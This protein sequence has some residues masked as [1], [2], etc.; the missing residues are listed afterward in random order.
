MALVSLGMV[1][2]VMTAPS[3]AAARGAPVT[4]SGLAQPDPLE[5]LG[6]CLAAGGEGDVLLVID[7]SGSLKETDPT[8]QRV[9]AA[10]YLV[11]QLGAY[12]KDS[13]TKLNMAVAGFDTSYAVTSPWRPLNASSIRG[14]SADLDVYKGADNGFE[15]DYWNAVD[16]ARKTL[17][18][19]AAGHVDRCQAWV[20]FSDGRYEIDPRNTQAQQKQYGTTKPYGSQASLTTKAGAD[21]AQ[22]AGLGD[23][24]RDGGLA[25]QLRVQKIVTLAVGLK[26]QGTDAD[27]SAMQGIA[28]GK[29]GG[30][31][32][33][34]HLLSPTPGEFLLASQVDGILFA[35]DRF[36]NPD[37][38]PISQTSKLCAA[39]ACAQGVH[40]FVLDPSISKIHILAGSNVAGSI[41]T[42]TGPG[43]SQAMMFKAGTVAA[44]RAGG[45][46]GLSS[47]WLSDR[48]LAIDLTRATD[49]GWVG[50]WK[51]TFIDPVS[52]SASG[53]AISNIH[54]FGDLEPFW[55]ASSTTAL[56]SGDKAQS[57]TLGLRRTQSKKPVDP[58]A[59]VSSLSVDASLDY[60]SGQSIPIASHIDKQGLG[61]AYR[62][63]L[64]NAKVGDAVIRMT[65]RVV[66]S[67]VGKVA[68]TALEAQSVDFPVKVLAPGSYPRVAG[69]VS[70]GATEGTEPL[71]ATV[72]VVGSGCVWLAGPQESLTRPDGV[73]AP[74][75]SSSY[76]TRD[77][78]LKISGKAS[79][80]MTLQ[81]GSTGNGL[82]S[83]TVNV[84]TAPT[85]ASLP[86]IAVKV[87]YQLEMSR[88]ADV[89]TLIWV[90]VLTLLAGI[91]I[92]V[93]LLYLVKWWNARIPGDSILVG[94]TTGLV[95]STGSFLADSG[96][97]PLREQDLSSVFLAGTDRRS[98]TV[99]GGGKTLHSKMG[100]GITEPGFVILAVPG[101]YSVSSARPSTVRK[102][103]KARLPLAV[104]GH[105]VAVLDAQDPMNGSVEVVLF[106][107]PLSG[108]WADL[109]ADARQRVPD[110]VD[111]L[112]QTVKPPAATDGSQAG[113]DVDDDW[114]SPSGSSSLQPSRSTT[115]SA[116]DD[117]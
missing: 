31:R 110:A 103:D 87:S 48:T 17:T 80:P 14:L 1:A 107:A 40:A 41:I 68:G 85:D 23:L 3:F 65:L 5:R 25:D 45:G 55:P 61:K 64:S 102:G 93:G 90:L 69:D 83:G 54:L 24:C 106:V 104:Q 57:I 92:P 7:R 39:K 52:V 53:K 77:K 115:G 10:K 75:I 15:T 27:F 46:Y 32:P 84:M 34:G 74:Q 26:A 88:P 89:K 70:F 47:S 58:A 9:V 114:G 105:W 94:T 71:S 13:G 66:T 20:W 101:R 21:R 30:A 36:G 117:W 49:G 8:A 62:L 16:G 91:L 116:D 22:A 29:G 2:L 73:A 44:P 99:P 56:H 38:A 79:L 112:R 96:Q 109:T 59:I 19:Q 18:Q 86:P 72:P 78:C 81:I 28:T 63:D 33:C 50:L 4:L 37:R 108:K 35:F 12:A 11:Q 98:L 82:A 76:S 42:L 51:L 113:A 111:K 100:L 95:A 43:Q 97:F 6:A 60:P 67:P